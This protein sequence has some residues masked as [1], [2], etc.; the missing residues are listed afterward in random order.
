MPA[1]DA[2]TKFFDALNEN[3]DAFIDAIRAANDRGH[4]VSTAFIEDA[5]RNQRETVELAAK[6]AKAP[7][8]F[9]GI[10]SSAMEMTTKAQGRSLDAARLWFGEMAGAQTESRELFQRVVNANRSA[11]DAA[12]GMARGFV[13]RAGESVQS[14]S[15]PTTN[16]AET[17]RST[18]E[19]SES[20]S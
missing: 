3:Y 8:D 9:A 14:L 16:G 5:Q 6:W 4:R 7:L 17:R 19:T 18:R 13:T 2:T 12:V 10:S 15:R 11:G 20:S 1:T